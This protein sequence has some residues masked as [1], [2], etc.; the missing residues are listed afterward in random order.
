MN[1]SYVGS[2]QRTF[3][4]AVTHLL[5]TEYGFLNSR[6]IIGMLAEDIEHLANEFHPQTAC[7]RSGWMV[8]TGTKAAGGKARPGQSAGEYSLVTLSWPVLLPEDIEAMIQMPTG[9]AGRRAR[10]ELLK[11]RLQRIIEHGLEHSDGSV[12]LTCADLG[13]M[14]GQTDS[15]ISYWLKQLREETGKTLITK[16]YYFDQGVRP[17]HKAEIVALY[18]QGKDEADIARYSDHAQSSVG[19]YL[20]DYER[21]KLLLG[22]NMT[23]EQIRPLTGLRPSVVDAYVELVHQYHPDLLSDSGETPIGS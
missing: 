3:Q 16:G 20:R 8:F 13:L 11:K 2:G 21:V 6:R 5:E 15:Q 17:S 10:S 9:E 23:V 1:T 18:E 22:H 19:R 4:Q 7:V 14:L 12:L